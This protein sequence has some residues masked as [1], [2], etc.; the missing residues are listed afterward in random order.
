MQYIIKLLEILLFGHFDQ[1]MFL[2]QKKYNL[3]ISV[4][5]SEMLLM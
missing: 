4:I 1:Y 3:I 2:R 5:A